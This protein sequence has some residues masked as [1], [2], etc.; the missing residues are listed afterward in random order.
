M[1]PVFTTEFWY[2]LFYGGYIVPEELLEDEEEIEN[3]QEAIDTLLAFY[4]KVTDEGLVEE[5]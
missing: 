5:G 3:V 2:D 4:E 1:E